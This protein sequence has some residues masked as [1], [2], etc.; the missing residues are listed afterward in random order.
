MHSRTWLP[1]AA[2]VCVLSVLAGSAAAQEARGSILG[3]VT[4]AQGAVIPGASVII[5]N[6]ATNSINR[7][8]T[9]ETGYYEVPLLVAGRYT[10]SAESAGFKKS[11][12]G[13]VELSVSSRL[14]INLQL[15]VGNVAETV[16]VTAEAPLL[17]TA[18]A[19]G[20]RV[21]DNRQ[22]MELPFS[23]MNPFALTALAAGM[24]WTGQPEYRRPFDNGGTSSFNTAGGVGQNEYSLDGSP[25]T[26]TGRRVGFVPPSDAVQEFKM[27]T[28]NFDA[29]FGHTSGAT[30]NVMTKSGTNVFHGSVYDQ[31]WQ[32]RWNATPHFTRLQWENAVQQGKISKDT[33]K[34]G[35]GR[36]NQ[37]GATVGGPVRVP[38]IYNGRD[39]AFFFFSYNGIYQKKAETTSDVN[40]GVPKMAWRQ[41]DFSDLLAID[42]V[43]YQIYDPRT[44]RLSGSRVIRDPFPGNRGVPVLNPL[45]R[46]YE[47]FYPA[48]N[49]VPGL[50][51]PEGFNNYLAAQMPKDERFNSLLNRADYN[52]N[53]K[54]K[55]FG[56]WY[57][58]HRLADEYDWTY[59]TARGLHSNG[60][61]RINK[62][63]GA[64][65]VWTI[66]GTTV[67]NLT[68]AFQRFNEGAVRPNQIKFKPSDVGLPAY[69][70]D[71]AGDYHMLPRLDFD[72]LEDVGS[73]YPVIDTRGS[74]AEARATL[75][76]VAG[77]HSLKFGWD[78][79]RYWR[80][81]AGPG[82]SSGSFSFRNTYMRRDDA[83]PLASHHG[84]EW[85][86]FMMGA[87]NGMSMD[88]ND[89][90]FWSTPWRSFFV[91]DDWRLTSR[92]R[93]NLGL[94][95]EWEQGTTE[96]F[97]RATA[98]GFDFNARLPFS[99]AVEAAYARSPLPELPPARFKA[100]GG[101][102]YMGQG[103]ARSWT[104]GTHNFL[105]RVG[106]VYQ[107]QSK[108]VIRAGYGWYYDTLNVNN[109]TPSRFGFN[110]GTGTTISTDNGLTFCCGA[111]FRA[112]RTPLS[113]P[114]PVRADGTRFNE[115]LRDSLGLVAVAGRGFNRDNLGNLTFVPRN[116][117][118]A[119]QQRWRFGIQH[120]FTNHIVLDVSY[121]GAF[122]RIWPS[123]ISQRVDF[124]PQEYW[125]TGN[126]RNN[127]I[128]T[129]LTR[130]LPNPFHFN[131][132][133][134]LAASNPALYNYLRTVSLFNGSNIR[135]ERLLRDYRHITAFYGLR[136]GEDFDASRGAVD[137]H[138]FQ[139]QLEKRFSRGFS[140]SILYT[141]ASSEAQDWI[142]NEFDSRPSWRINNNTRPHRFVS[143]GIWELPFGK[144]RRM[145]TTGPLQH[146]L[147]G[148][149]IGWIY[150]RNSGP[151]PDWGNRFFYGDL[152]KIEALFKHDEVHSRNIH[153][154]FDPSIAYKGSGPVPDGFQGF[155]GRSANQPG[156]FHVRVFPNRLGALRSDGIR[157][158]DINVNRDF[159]IR[160]DLKVRFGVDLLNAT[161]HTNFSG[162]SLDPT[163]SNF[164]SITSQ[165]GLSRVIQFNLR[166]QF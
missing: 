93:L 1:V 69:L 125:A 132:F 126:V 157:N 61:T 165:R 104:D 37:F 10:I 57:W 106:L 119:F 105:P 34:Q 58:N 85:A 151:V 8:T 41:G 76:K 20:G 109:D 163:S 145:I 17:E 122:S 81:S 44:A 15:E 102:F 32:Q 3:R 147:G 127:A 36:S 46:F 49:D 45:Y 27:E 5:T 86:A 103:D 159:R 71:R 75:M 139:I 25:V 11:L 21:I 83:D 74:T 112:G 68:V 137:Y 31:H 164:G 111:D 90:A 35:T 94:R 92:L 100:Q 162:P 50:A 43:K 48:P 136:P 141:Y 128:E 28:A 99:D 63:A 6:V 77:S 133:P 79:R 26:G 152:S 114:F 54:H 135:K 115:P 95:Y 24:Q 39:S 156:S 144:G 16:T 96:R 88:T 120:Q 80:T 78:E 30:I 22:I 116:Y 98:G 38:K 121:N 149:Q 142:A 129:E 154:W 158:W 33:P 4:D 2:A 110:Q 55:I 131:N 66:S 64:D 51:T 73:G 150:Q 101:G 118:P 53:E 67:F 60:L 108:T 124:L 89:T 29:A 62:G 52:F 130:N 82:N 56:R 70:D 161:N 155:E 97:N 148:W 146:V 13:P 47:K 113:D 42:P 107:V 12:R 23:D 123:G 9:N 65:Y 153:T 117:R 19:S 166:V 40:R 87:T 143:T 18:S 160:E 14:E 84:L 91:Q 134:A 138:D 140:T 59:E 7:V 72:S